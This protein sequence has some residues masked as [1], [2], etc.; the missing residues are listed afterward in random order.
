MLNV[1]IPTFK[2]YGATWVRPL[3]TRV[4]ICARVYVYT[5][6]FFSALSCA[7]V[8]VRA[9]IEGEGGIPDFLKPMGTLIDPQFHLRKIFLKELTSK[10]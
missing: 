3:Y 10:I 7:C 8:C 4:Y 9:C 2:W 6:L 1:E 5:V